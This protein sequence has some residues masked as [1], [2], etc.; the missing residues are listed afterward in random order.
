MVFRIRK[1]LFAVTILVI[2]FFAIIGKS[3]WKYEGYTISKHFDFSRK[4]LIIATPY[5]IGGACHPKIVYFEN[6]FNNY[7]YWMAYTPYQNHNSRYENP[8]ILASNDL[9]I[10]EV[11]KGLKNPCLDDLYNNKDKRIYNSDTHILFNNDTNQIECWWRYVNDKDNYVKIYRRV[12]QNGEYWH[13]KEVVRTL[14]NRKKLDYVSLSVLYNNKKYKIYYVN[15][16][17]IWMTSSNDLQTYS[18]PVLVNVDFENKIKPWHI[19]VEKT[20]NGYEM[21]FVAYPK[22]QKHHFNMNL[23]Y[24]KSEDGYNWSKPIVI[25]KPRKYKSWDDGGIYRSALLKVDDV[26]HVIYTGWSKV[27]KV[28][29]G[30]VQGVDIR[31]LK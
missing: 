26:Y 12:S 7:K 5:D 6:G 23:Y 3:L 29:L 8:C 21:V 31:S 9:D 4:Q 30:H 25:L 27:G 15:K 22:N 16:N 24:C 19:D 13:P 17:R 14:K 11:P 2:L 1:R 28:G 10:W 20:S 18:E